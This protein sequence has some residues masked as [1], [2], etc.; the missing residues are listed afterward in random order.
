VSNLLKIARRVDIR[1]RRS[2]RSNLVLAVLAA[3]GAQVLFWGAFSYRETPKPPP[4]RTSS[5][6]MVGA[7]ET[8]AIDDWIDFHDPA[9]FNRGG[10]RKFVPAVGDRVTAAVAL[11]RPAPV[12]AARRAEV[13][14][15]REIALPESAPRTVLPLPPPP[16]PPPVRRKGGITDGAGRPLP[17]NGVKL[18]PRTSGAG[19]RTILRV[20]NPGRFPTLMVDGSCGDPDL[21]RRAQQL[22]MPLAVSERAPEFIIVEWPEPSAPPKPGVKP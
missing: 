16:L 21:D 7:R 3:V 2:D 13:G 18:P 9:A 1:S 12:S 19:E 4:E 20:L 22:A 15:Y 8:A 14:K 5:V 10:Y 11:R 17:L 6:T